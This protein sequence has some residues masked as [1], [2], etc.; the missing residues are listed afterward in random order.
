MKTSQRQIDNPQL[1]EA[2][3]NKNSKYPWRRFVIDRTY[4]NDVCFV[5]RKWDLRYAYK[6]CFQCSIEEW[7]EFATGSISLKKWSN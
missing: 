3:F 7:K 4:G 2:F 5:A 6:S 1:G